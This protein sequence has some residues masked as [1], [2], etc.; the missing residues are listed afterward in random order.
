M[1]ARSFEATRDLC[2]ELDDLIQL[3][4]ENRAPIVLSSICEDQNLTL[5]LDRVNRRHRPTCR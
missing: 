2:T 5:D 3:A 4:I 1:S